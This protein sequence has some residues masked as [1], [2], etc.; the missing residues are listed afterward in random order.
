MQGSDGALL[1]LPPQKSCVFQGDVRKAMKSSDGDLLQLPGPDRLKN[2]DKVADRRDDAPPVRR[3]SQA[4][5]DDT[6]DAARYGEGCAAFYDEIYPPPGSQ[7]L[8]LLVELAAGGAVLEAGVGTG[9][10]ALPLLARGLSVHGIE[11]SP[12]M[13]R[14]LRRKPG[15]AALSLTAGDFSRVSAPGRYA[16]ALCLTDTLALLPDRPSQRAALQRLARS[17]APGARLLLETAHSGCTAP[18]EVDIEFLSAAGKRSYRV[19]LLP[20]HLAELDGWAA[21][22]GLRLTARWRNWQAQDWSGESGM[23]LSLYVADGD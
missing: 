18:A 3:P 10:Y 9:R 22:C 7:A 21:A 12:A 1:D 20:L 11:A 5:N 16:L 4:M 8:R 19:S 6:A 17:L 14:Q 13:R 2:A 23:V 15:A